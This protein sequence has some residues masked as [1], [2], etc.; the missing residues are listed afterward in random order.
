MI[1]HR[2]LPFDIHD[3]RPLPGVQPLG[4]APWLLVD[5]AYAGQMAERA[6][7]LAE[8][9]AEVLQLSQAGKAAAAELLQT[10]L[11]ALPEGFSTAGDTVRRPDGGSLRIDPDDPL[12]TLGHLV[13]EDLCLLEKQGEEHILTG[14]VLCFPASWRLAEKFMRPLT[15]IHAP[16]PDYDAGI[17]RRVQRLFDGLQVG[18]PIWRFN[19]LWYDDPTLHQPRSRGAPRP[20]SDPGQAPFLRSERQC[21]LRLP[22]T[23][24]VVFSIH[25][26]VLAQ[27]DVPGGS[28]H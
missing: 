19:R 17:A 26:Y 28:G 14:A 10:V 20:L 7:L 15:D 23:R 6:R 4:D 13:Q 16:V 3:A 8:R 1:L 18:R 9:R 5:E 21:L 27:A 2:R 12:G 11:A 24:A 25:T 22:V